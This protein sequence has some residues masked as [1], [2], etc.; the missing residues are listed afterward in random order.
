MEEATLAW[1][2]LN[3]KELHPLF[4]T[5]GSWENQRAAGQTDEKTNSCTGRVTPTDLKG[6][7]VCKGCPGHSVPFA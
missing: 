5:K 2:G 6:Y 4:Q 7:S 3:A 1:S